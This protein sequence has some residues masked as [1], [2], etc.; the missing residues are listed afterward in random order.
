MQPAKLSA[1]AID[2]P[3]FQGILELNAILTTLRQS[4]RCRLQFV[5]TVWARYHALCEMEQWFLDHLHDET[6]CVIPFGAPPQN[7]SSL[8]GEQL[9]V[10][11]ERECC[12]QLT[13]PQSVV[14]QQIP[15]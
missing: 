3:P 4:I 12:S 11:L 10:V 5:V 14:Y 9:L 8:E 2:F 13:E 1:L 6:A 7:P 15:S